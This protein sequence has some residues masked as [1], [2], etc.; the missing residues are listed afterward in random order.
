MAANILVLPRE[1][2]ALVFDH[3]VELEGP[4][5]LSAPLQAIDTTT[6]RL[7]LPYRALPCRSS[8][9]LLR[10]SREMQRIYC[11]A[12][13]RYLILPTSPI[14]VE[15]RDLAFTGAI[16]LLCTT[17]ATFPSESQVQAW[18]TRLHS[19]RA[20]TLVLIPV[21]LRMTITGS[22]FRCLESQ[23]Q[24]DAAWLPRLSTWLKFSAGNVVEVTYVV[25]KANVLSYE[26]YVNR[27]QR[28][29]RNKYD[30]LQGGSVHEPELKHIS[31]VKTML[32]G[33][34]IASEEIR[35]SRSRSRDIE[36]SSVNGVRYV[37]TRRRSG[38]GS[39][40]LTDAERKR[41]FSGLP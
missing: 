21:Q 32:R 14:R 7:N 35:T 30:E 9:S 41:L 38:I 13:R 19:L 36:A 31:T 11:E 26:E 29:L 20:L 23:A 8:N 10:V 34:H 1:L 2:Q 12:V 25:R 18:T 17:T 39:A 40:G 6:T 15:V 33:V 5:T 4:I 22:S 27:M 16:D 3:V 28:F 37:S 24:A